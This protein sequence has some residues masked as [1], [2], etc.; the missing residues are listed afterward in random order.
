MLPNADEQKD[1]MDA[2]WIDQEREKSAGVVNKM[3]WYWSKM[4]REI[5]LGIEVNAYIDQ[6]W[7]LK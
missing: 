4:G 5:K 7:I 1:C 6:G 2:R 3:V